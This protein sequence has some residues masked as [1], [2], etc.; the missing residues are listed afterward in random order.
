MSIRTK[1]VLVALAAVAGIAAAGYAAAPWL[2]ATIAA[3]SLE[4]V[5][6]VRE[7]DIESV[8]LSRIEVAAVGLSSSRLRLD[9]HRATIR[10]DPW[11]FRIRGV[12]VRRAGLEL[13]GAPG[14]AGGGGIPAPP[15]FP[16]RV[17]ELSLAA[18][19]PW[20]KVAFS[21][22]VEASRGTAGGLEATI[23]GPGF[24]AA[25]TNPAAGRHVLAL[26]DGESRDMLSLNARTDQGFP[27]AF[28]GVVNP[29]RLVTW[30]QET[31]AL[32]PDLKPALAPYAVAGNAL[33]LSGT[34]EQSLDFSAEL[35]GGIT[36]R[37]TR[38][39]ADRLFQA[40]ELNAGPGYAV[41]RAGAYWHGS[42]NAGFTFATGPD[43]I[44]SGRNPS[45]RWD[46]QGLSFSAAAARLTPSAMEADTVE[47]NATTVE[48]GRAA[49]S[50]RAQGL[51]LDNWPGTL[52]HYDVAG[53]WSW[54][55]GSLEAAGTGDGSGVPKLGW[56]LAAAGAQ[57]SLEIT[58]QDT[59][60][61]IAPSLEPYAAVVAPDLKILAGEL[62]G[63]YRTD[64]SADGQ[65]T[66]LELDAASVNAGLGGMEIRGLD[67]RVDNEQNRVDRLGV[68]LSAPSLKL[69]AGTIAEDLDVK[70]R[71][72]PEKV[73]VNTART[74]LFDGEISLRPVSFSPDDD[75][76]VL[77]ADI[78]GLSLEKVIALLEQDTTDMTGE[79]AGPVRI[80]LNTETGIEINKGDLH[81]VRGGV[82]RVHLNQD[83]SAAAQLNNIALRALEDFQYEE[84]NA[85]VL[86]KPDGEYRIEAR[87]LGRNPEVLDGHP[88][89][90][91]PTIEGR[92]PALFRAFFITGD[93]NRAIIERLQQEQDL[94]TPGET[95]TFESD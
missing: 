60:A 39:E 34:L 86:Y 82:L 30:L 8:G 90:L 38:D 92:L 26:Q 54:R 58:V 63:R 75:T 11:P 72:S 59:V 2:L 84:L 45:W 42:G 41:A 1:P 24:S 49:G 25:L 81:S 27:V 6:E 46:D 83:A 15:P 88:I 70:L 31:P 62:S 64:W 28:D 5:V 21:A 9:A 18:A 10:F 68:A 23:N 44:F 50:L 22:S 33:Q 71:V 14:A 43:T 20:G 48:A 87:I 13:T 67:V 55:R 78:D 73:H 91:N 61:A 79:V 35:A 69:A 89:A 53:D 17:D 65:E 80:V 4:G 47:V 29:E 16:L 36:L 77:L 51:R 94:S 32:P 66:Q 37:D 85:S 56:K 57:G 3:R 76:I 7:L 19:A 74:R 93:F 40:L 52:S 95:P 12:E